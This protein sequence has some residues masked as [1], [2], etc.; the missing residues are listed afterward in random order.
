M[1]NNHLDLWK[2]TK[3]HLKSTIGLNSYNNY[4]NEI[5]DVIG[6]NN[7]TIILQVPNNYIKNKIDKLYLNN[8]N[9]F[10]TTISADFVR[11]K[12]LTESEYIK[13]Q[14]ETT[15][16]NL[17]IDLE[18]INSSNLNQTYT[19]RNYVPGKNNRLAVTTAIKVAD[20]PGQLANPFY[21]FGKV[22]IGKTHLMQSIGNYIIE[23][24][25]SMKVLYVKTQD[26]IEDYANAAQNKSYQSFKNKYRNYDI[27]LVDDIQFLANKTKTQEEFFKI[28]ELMHQENKQIV[29]T[30]DRPS[31]ELK[32]IMERLTSRFSWGMSAD[33]LAPDLEHRIEILKRKVSIN[34]INENEIS[35]EVL[36]TIAENFK[37]NVR[38]LEGALNRVLFCNSMDLDQKLTPKVTLEYLASII[39]NDELE[40]VTDNSNKISNLLEIVCSYFNITISSIIGPSRKSE[41]VYPRQISIY[42]IRTKYNIPYAKIGKFFNNRDH[43][44]IMSSY[45]KIEVGQNN[46]QNIKKDLENLKIKVEN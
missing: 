26:F 19:F 7:N 25:Y 43:S 11:F 44:T 38:E 23:S 28:F 33:I 16:N 37:D 15:D 8:I 18:S 39:C 32:N 17:L 35:Y 30:S 27:L 10:T 12:F 36:K 13:E 29:I 1:L 42:L 24:N 45:H 20:N 9:N 34:L 6:S 2:K 40:V 41:F 22:G 31:A 21:I 14:K 3:Q 5:N 46:N 4:F